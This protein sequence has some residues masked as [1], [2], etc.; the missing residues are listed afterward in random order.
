MM[1][2]LGLLAL[3]FL[4]AAFYAPARKLCWWLPPQKGLTVFMY[5]HV[6]I[7]APTDGQ[8]FFTVT[9]QQFE[10]H[11]EVLKKLGKTPIGLT[12]LKST[13]VKNPVMLTFD[14]GHQDN[15]TTLFPLLKKHHIKAVIFLITE[16][17]GTPG[18]ITWQQARE[19]QASGWVEFGS[20]TATHQR[21]RKI[22]DAEIIRELAQSRATIQ[23][24]LGFLPDAFCYP[25]G[26]GAFDKRVRALVL[27]AG[28]VYDFST[29]K[30]VNSWPLNP[31]KPIKRAF[32]RGGESTLDFTL[33]VTRGR[34]RF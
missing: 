1:W 17:I 6:A 23:K 27:Q 4:A 24:E 7:T 16:K 15:Y 20:H 33:Q 31:H 12:D 5:H 26:A 19:M 21:L 25:F 28:F 29:K 13:A 11:L 18:F 14:D 32:P 8:Y 3:P 22:S 34:S 10:S 2:L 30:G 9:P